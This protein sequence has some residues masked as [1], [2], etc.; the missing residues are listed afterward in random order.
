MEMIEKLFEDDV[1]VYAKEKGWEVEKVFQ[2]ERG[3]RHIWVD[4]DPL[5]G[6]DGSHELVNINSGYIFTAPE[7]QRF[8]IYVG[9]APIMKQVYW[10]WE[11]D[12]LY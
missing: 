9:Y 5:T 12:N 1:K 2:L 11:H 4:V 8:K 7:R 3:T 10:W 6:L